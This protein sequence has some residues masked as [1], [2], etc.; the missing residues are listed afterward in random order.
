MA[1]PMSERGAF[2]RVRALRRLQSAHGICLESLTLE[3]MGQVRPQRL[4]HVFAVA[5]RTGALR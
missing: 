1:F 3:Q 4:H 5:S 2:G